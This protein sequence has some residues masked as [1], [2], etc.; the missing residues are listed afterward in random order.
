MVTLQDIPLDIVFEDEHLL[1][2]NKVGPHAH[3]ANLVLQTWCWRVQSV[4]PHTEC[5]PFTIP[6][7]L[8]VVRCRRRA[9]WCTPRRA[10]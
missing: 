1:V 5:R 9:W 4:P 3:V 7:Q 10:T 6:L 2:I 8:F